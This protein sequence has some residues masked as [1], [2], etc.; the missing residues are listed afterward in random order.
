M[1]AWR[2]MYLAIQPADGSWQGIVQCVAAP[3]TQWYTTGLVHVT[4]PRP[5]AH[6]VGQQVVLDEVGQVCISLSLRHLDQ[7]VM[8]GRLGAGNERSNAAGV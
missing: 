2:V 1:Q 8:C 3:S 7:A 4:R 6:L 5:P